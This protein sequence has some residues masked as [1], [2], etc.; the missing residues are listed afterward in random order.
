MRGALIRGRVHAV[1]MLPVAVTTLIF[2]PRVSA[3]LESQRPRFIQPVK[4]LVKLRR[5]V[6]VIV[7]S[8][9]T[10]VLLE[11]ADDVAENRGARP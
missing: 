8:A 3:G 10:L 7:P 1:V 6:V 11:R 5:R 9:T 4:P 2:A